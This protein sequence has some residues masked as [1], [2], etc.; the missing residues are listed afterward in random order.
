MNYRQPY[1]NKG[2]FFQSYVPRNP[3]DYFALSAK[4]RTVLWNLQVAVWKAQHQ[5][6]D[7]CKSNRE[8]ILN[9]E[10]T[11]YDFFHPLSGAFFRPNPDGSDDETYGNLTQDSEI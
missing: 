3:Q 1:P 7:S 8:L 5:L 11:E 2:Y 4:E 9:K 10:E 6:L